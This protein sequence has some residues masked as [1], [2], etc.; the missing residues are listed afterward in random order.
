MLPTSLEELNRLYMDAEQVDRELYSEMRSNVLL[1]AGEHYTKN[2]TKQFARLRETNRL[3]ET[4]KLRLTKN[5]IHRVVRMYVNAILA[6]A[7][8]VTVLP[9]N[10]SELQDQ[11]DAEQNKMVIK[12]VDRMYDMK[13]RIR[14]WAEEYVTIGEVATKAFWDPTKGRLLGYEQKVADDGTPIFLDPNGQETVERGFQDPQTGEIFEFEQAMDESL[15]V[16]SG[17]IEFEPLFGFN[18]FRAPGAHSMKVSPYIGL[19]KMTPIDELKFKYKD[20]PEK[21]KFI[22]ESKDTDFIVFDSGKAI[23]EKKEKWVLVKECYWKPCQRYPE[24]YYFIWTDSGILEQGKLPY[25][26]YPIRWKGFDKYASTPRGRSIIKVARPYQAEINR[27]ASQRATHGITLADDKVLYQAG[28]KLAPGGL[29]PGVRGVTYQGVPPTILPGRNGDQFTNYLKDEKAELYEATMLSEETS[30]EQ[31]NLDPY[32][33]LFRTMGQQAKYK[34]YIEQFEEYLVDVYEYIL[35]LLRHYLPDEDLKEMLGPKEIGNLAEFRKKTPQ[36]YRIALEPQSDSVD[37]ML[38]KQ[39]TLNHLLQYVGKNMQPEQLGQI[40]RNMPFVNNEEIFSDLTIDYDNVKNDML[41]IER[42]EQ[43]MMSPYANNEYYVKKLTHRMKQADFKYLDQGIQMIYQQYMQLH[44]QEIMRKQIAVQ[45]AKN[46]YVPVGGAMITLSMRM[47]DPDGKGSKQVRLPYQSVQWLMKQL[48]SQG[49]SLEDLENM[50]QG[51]L[52][53]I[54]G[55]MQSQQID[56]GLEP[57]NQNLM[58][59]GYVN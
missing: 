14:D 50:N 43:P 55:Q 52:A 11:K 47:P 28:T 51:A 10:E 22:T 24:G 27:S 23:Y 54:A 49:N 7:P 20:D 48:E 32:T 18:L 29:L 42:G 41:A 45:Q 59:Q 3:T 17:A 33:L 35:E 46:E 15:P 25:G 36:T 44:Q 31:M 16:F 2:S 40:M 58:Q 39:L 12:S 9:S 53:E 38:G 56:R 4:L 8:G 1:Q 37:T 34:K 13:E 21:V 30:E 26:L 19:R 6:K 57:Q 5:H